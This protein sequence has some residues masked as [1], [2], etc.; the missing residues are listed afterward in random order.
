MSQV[1]LTDGKEEVKDGAARR[2]KFTGAQI[3]IHTILLL[4]VLPL[5]RFPTLPECAPLP[6]RSPPSLSSLSPA[7]S[8]CPRQFPSI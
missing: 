8:A 2:D 4:T 6:L 5:S 1:K 7:R 3:Y